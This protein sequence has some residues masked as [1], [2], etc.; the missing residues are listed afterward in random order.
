MNKKVFH[1]KNIY[2]L[3]II[4]IKKKINFNFKMM[5]NSNNNNHLSKLIR[6]KN[7]ILEVLLLMILIKQILLN[8]K[9]VYS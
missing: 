3:I 5:S 2:I 4:R 7:K 9:I 1:L 6:T 8:N